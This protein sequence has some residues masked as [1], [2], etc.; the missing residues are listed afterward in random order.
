MK[1]E[2]NEN[3]KCLPF[4]FD[5]HK[6]N[7]VYV[8]GI[9]NLMKLKN[10]IDNF[11]MVGIDTETRP[12]FK[13]RSNKSPTSIIQIATRCSLNNEM[14]YILDLLK[15]TSGD[16]TKTILDESCELLFSNKNITKIG[17][18]LVQDLME[19]RSS[20][21][22]M[23]CFKRMYSILETNSMHRQLKPNVTQNLSLKNFVRMYLNFN[24]IKSQQLSDWGQRPLTEAQ[25]LYA[26]C[27]ALV[28]LR[29]YDAIC[30]EAE[31]IFGEKS[32]FHKLIID[33]LPGSSTSKNDVK[34]STN[35]FY[36]TIEYRYNALFI[37]HIKN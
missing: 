28:L 20:Y 4:V 13:K 22:E 12:N 34:K 18:G 26:A 33:I 31:D 37:L 35:G 7:L 30:Y 23:S 15:L 14:V 17:H 5:L 9:E 16:E 8:D 29:L 27:D 10:S 32:N 21:P 1:F 19:L 24:L 6:E 3:D 11:V 36:N 2:L 25:I